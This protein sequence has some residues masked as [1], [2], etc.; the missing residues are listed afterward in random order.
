MSNTC[1]KEDYFYRVKFVIESML[2]LYFDKDHNEGYSFLGDINHYYETI[3]KTER[4]LELQEF[5][6]LVVLIL[7]ERNIE[8]G[9]LT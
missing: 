8:K 5:E 3:I 6:G 7:K 4:V 2:D 1:E 9:S